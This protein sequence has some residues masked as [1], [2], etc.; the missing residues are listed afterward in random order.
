MTDTSLE[1]RL[2]SIV[3]KLE[4]EAGVTTPAQQAD[5]T[6]T[7][8][9]KRLDDAIRVD[10][11]L[12]RA[13]PIG[14]LKDVTLINEADDEVIAL[15]GKTW[16][17]KAVAT[18]ATTIRLKNLADVADTL[19]PIAEQVFTFT[20]AEWDATTLIHS[21][22]TGLVSSDDH[23]RYLLADGSRALSANWDAG[24]FEITTEDLT[25]QNDITV[26]GEMKGSRCTFFAGQKE[27]FTADSYAQGTDGSFMTATRG[28]QMHR[29]GS[30]VGI[31]WSLNVA[32]V[33]AGGTFAVRIRKNGVNAFARQLT[34]MVTGDIGHSG[35]QNR[36]LDTFLTS[37]VLTVFLDFGT[38]VGTIGNVFVFFEVV[39]DT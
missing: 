17:N 31:G 1:A 26:D 2:E 24:D 20:G 12:G 37:D 13:T 16:V 15:A 7:A 4:T 30:I 36:G 27:N 18:V 3:T 11:V 33:T 5:Q 29:P 14:G 38:F 21:N 35:I 34:L 10:T 19:T 25:V 9:L 39:F 23:K 6:L 28:Y 32:A 8:K 22:L